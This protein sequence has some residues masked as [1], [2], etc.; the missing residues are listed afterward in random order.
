MTKLK[1]KAPSSPIIVIALAVAVVAGYLVYWN[2]IQPQAVVADTTAEVVQT[3]FSFKSVKVGGNSFVEIYKKN[4]LVQ[5]VIVKLGIVDETSFK[6]STDQSSVSFDVT[7]GKS[8]LTG[9]IN[10]KTFKYSVK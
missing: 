5:T 4:E 2:N 7:S 1:M 6:V 8:K 10:L 9:V 3:D